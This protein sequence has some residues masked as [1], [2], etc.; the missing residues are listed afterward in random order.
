MKPQQRRHLILAEL[1]ALQSELSVEE[2]AKKFNV[3]T[4]TVRRDLDYL[5]KNGVVLRTHGGCVLQNALESA[6]NRRIALNFQL[7]QAIGR[8]AAREVKSGDTIMIT[9]GSTTFHLARHLGHID[10]LSVF[11]NSMPIISELGRFVGMRLFIL[12]GE[13]S[14]KMHII[15]G[16][17]MQQ[18]LKT[19][20]FD[21]IFA[22]TEAIDEQGRCLVSDPDRSC[23]AQAVLARGRHRILLADHTKVGAKGHA[24]YA[25]LDD[26]D[27]WYTTAGIS[28]AQLRR[29]RQQTSVQVVRA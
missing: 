2:L 24:I 22:G 17:L 15:G 21:S 8:A 23:L 3:S 11:T 20:H 6:Y 7:K 16:S 27:V 9:D 25:T 4:L 10:R 26:F 1:R 19:L 12:G 18:N 5:E 14:P 13:Y 29:Y 28:P